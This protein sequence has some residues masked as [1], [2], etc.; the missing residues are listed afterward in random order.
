LIRIDAIAL[1]TFQLRAC[2]LVPDIFYSFQAFVIIP[3]VLTGLALVLVVVSIFFSQDETNAHGLGPCGPAAS[4]RKE[5]GTSLNL[6]MELTGHQGQTGRNN[7]LNS[8]KEC[9]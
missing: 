1:L 4:H 6:R 3:C 5:E 8:R 7:P 2:K 9:A